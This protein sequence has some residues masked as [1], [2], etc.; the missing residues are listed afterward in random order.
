MEYQEIAEGT[1]LSRPNR[2]LAWVNIGGQDTLCH[3]KNTGRCRELL[4][5]GARVIVEHHTNPARKTAYSL[6][7]VYKGD[8]LFNMDS[9]AP[10]QAAWE[11]AVRRGADGRFGRLLSVRREA[12]YG[13]SRFDLYLEAAAG[14]TGTPDPA[15]TGGEGDGRRD[16][17]PDGR[18][19]PANR[20]IFME[21]KGVTLEANGIARFPD[22]PTERG[23]KH[24]RE[25]IGCKQ[26]GYEACLLFVVQR[27][28]V[29]RVEPNWDTQPAF[30]EALLEARQAGVQLLAYDC[31]VTPGSLRLDAPVAVSLEKR[32]AWALTQKQWENRRGK[33]A[34]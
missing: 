11:W 26:A 13:Q 21:V 22:A 27:K 17:D 31:I 20:R 7:G 23:L 3:V 28:G 19:L 33:Q 12:R 25:L 32:E 14:A 9:Q 18:E 16:R 2:F 15:E 10:N 4:I 6:I 8:V 24:V 5:P 29:L 34:K 1:F 30:G